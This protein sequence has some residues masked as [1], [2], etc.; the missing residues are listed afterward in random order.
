V[1]RIVGLEDYPKVRAAIKAD[2]AIRMVDGRYSNG[3]VNM[4]DLQDCIVKRLLVVEVRDGMGFAVKP[5]ARNQG[6][7][8]RKGTNE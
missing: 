7:L 6:Q 5:N 3:F 8:P 1:K 4:D 2:G